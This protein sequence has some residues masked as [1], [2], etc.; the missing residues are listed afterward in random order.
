M[1]KYKNITLLSIIS[2]SSLLILI[3]YF[4][5]FQLNPQ[6]L[7]ICDVYSEKVL[8]FKSFNFEFLYPLNRCDD[9]IYLDTVLN[10]D[11]IF[12]EGNN[13]YQNRPMYL[14]SNYL[15]YQILG[16]LIKSTNPV[17]PLMPEISYLI[18]QLIYFVLGV[19]LI[20]KIL[21]KYFNITRIDIFAVTILFSLN[22]LIQFGIFTPSNH[23][24][25][26]LVFVVAL[27]FL[28][29]LDTSR[30]LFLYSALLGILF[31]LNRSFFITLM[32]VNIFFVYKNRFKYKILIS[33]IAS[34]FIFFI[35]NYL[36]K[37]YLSSKSIL[38]YD[39]NTEYYGQ[40]IWLSKYFNQGI[41]YWISKI[42]LPNK[43]FNLRLTKSWETSDEWYCQNLPDNFICYAQDSLNLLKYLIVPALLVIIFIFHNKFKSTLLKKVFLIGIIAYMFWSL[44]G[45]YPPIRFNLYSLGN[46]LFI[47]L[48]IGFL[49]LRFF[50]YK[51][52]YF[53]ISASYLFNIVH[54]NNPDLFS[55]NVV[56]LSSFI[57][58]AVFGL[59][60]FS[61]ILKT[62]PFT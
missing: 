41:G 1:N 17:F 3:M 59:V 62:K 45:W 12:S 11:N 18:V 36:Y 10:L 43:L 21:M 37:Q 5:F 42:L 30:Q 53:I 60:S 22:P 57:V 8:Y 46:F 51:L 32:A 58:L 33:N 27:Y 56:T 48:V 19:F 2:G 44:I 50:K 39:I 40:F 52:F 16:L 14:F 6:E 15:I 24:L 20:I 49:N 4:V 25:T 31:L 38:L 55:L 9:K 35:P 28:E 29:D 7:F 26:F 13:P 47:L 23:T 54:W 61:N 34:V